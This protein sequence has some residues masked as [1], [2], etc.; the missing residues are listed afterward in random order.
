MTDATII[1]VETKPVR[2]L[3]RWAVLAGAV[4]LFILGFLGWGLVNTNAPRPEP[5]SPAPGFEVQF[6]N[7]Y[8]WE[9]RPA[10]TLEEMK[11]QVVVLNFWASWCIECRVEADLLENTWRAYQDQGVVF[12]G[13]AYIDVEPQ[14]IAYMEEFNITY[15]N[16]PDL[17]S[18]I[19]Q[20][21]KVTGVPETFFIG[22][23]GLVK[24][25][26][27]GP[28]SPQRLTSTIERLLAEDA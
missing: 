6:F 3:N 22:K 21:Y 15:P 9:T 7:G 11:G 18:R 26:V 24:D 10:A 1:P 4:T 23:D 14:S 5:G 27:I 17:R 25:I 12:L 28:V 16:A 13:V 19:S 20:D 2:R 8:E